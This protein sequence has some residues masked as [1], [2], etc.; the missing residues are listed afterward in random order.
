MEGGGR[1][2][3]SLG[4]HV[5][6]SAARNALE[7]TYALEQAAGLKRSVSRRSLLQ[8]HAVEQPDAADGARSGGA[9]LLIRVFDGLEGA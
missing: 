9:P 1:L 3:I 7:E 8:G 4:A 2:E 6:P 5:T